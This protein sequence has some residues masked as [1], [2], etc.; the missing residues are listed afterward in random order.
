M[1]DIP[2]DGIPTDVPNPLGKLLSLIDSWE[3]GDKDGTDRI[4][5]QLRILRQE[6]RWESTR[7]NSCKTSYVE[8]K[9]RPAKLV[10]SAG[11]SKLCYVEL[12]R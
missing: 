6:R 8:S 2:A 10:S 11:T 9:G 4:V 5:L 3:E 1:Y 7:W 12:G